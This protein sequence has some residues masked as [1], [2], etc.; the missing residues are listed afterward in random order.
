M[1]R[2]YEH[3]RDKTG[4]HDNHYDATGRL[5]PD[6]VPDPG[7]ASHSEDLFQK[8]ALSFI[9]GN[10][11][12]PFFLYYATQLPHGPCITPDLGVYKDK[13]WD[14]KHKEWAAMM[15]HLDVGVG[16]MVA[17]LDELGIA[18]NTIIF[19]AGDNGYS[20]WGYFGRK[21]YTDDPL[22][23]NKGPWPKGKFTCTHE[24]G[25]RVPF[26][27]H[28][29]GRVKAGENPHPC[30]L[31]DFLATAADLADVTAPPTDG[32]S[33]LP[34]LLGHSDRQHKHGYF[35]WE[36]GTHSPHAQSARMSQWW[37]TRSHPAQPIALYRL[38]R[39][40]ACEHDLAN[41]HPDIVKRFEAIFAEAHTDS[42]WYINPGESKAQ[43]DAKKEEARA[44]GGMQIPTRAN[45]VFPKG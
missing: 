6:G 36:N 10:K 12:K 23:R 3:T 42:T 41:D 40:L 15:T 9:R 24:G 22:F 11:D 1:P 26:F 5:I 7:K 27:V 44:V 43:I 45:T 13:D 33:L 35:Y 20:H 14:Q 32:I 39:D 4:A 19:F 34:T 18:K 37:A 29:P 16:K 30:A 38:D 17:L 31:Y 8:E 28:W 21:P 25:L 2:V